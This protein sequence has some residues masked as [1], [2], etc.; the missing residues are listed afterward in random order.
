MNNSGKKC[1]SSLKFCFFFL[2]K[3]VFFSLN[4]LD[5]QM[6]I[7][8]VPREVAHIRARQ[9]SADEQRGF[10]EMMEFAMTLQPVIQ[11]KLL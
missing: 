2:Q 5:E 9:L 10:S 8:S 7:Y 1:F 11:N 6:K 4:P 3:G